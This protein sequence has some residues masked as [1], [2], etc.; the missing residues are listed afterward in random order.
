MI[1]QK[2]VGLIEVLVSLLVLSVG[3]LGSA[4]LQTLS[5]KEGVQS[6]FR[7]RAQMVSDD[8]FA[9]MLANRATAELGNYSETPLSSEPTPNCH[10]D[11]CT[12]AEMAT[13]DLWQV[14]DRLEGEAALP[15]AAISITF[16]DVT[17]AYEIVLTWN[18]KNTSDSYSAP[19]CSATDNKNSGCLF[20][21]MRF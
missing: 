2:G 9:R 12:G 14:L 10:V 18:A 15:D 4:S 13:H 8:L 11:A 7:S 20:T 17:L 21:A 6:N 16:D 1:K 5:L 19:T 3:L